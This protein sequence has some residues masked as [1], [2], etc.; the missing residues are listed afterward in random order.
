MSLGEGALGQVRSY[1]VI[2]SLGG[3]CSCSQ[4]LRL[5]GLQFASF[6]C[7]WLFGGSPSVRARGLVDDFAGWFD[8]G[9]L[10]RHEIPWQLE[11]E[12]WINRQNGIVFKH[13]FDWNRPLDVSLPAVREKYARRGARLLRLI[14]AAKRVLAVYLCPPHQREI[15]EE[16]FVKALG[17]L[18]DRFPAVAIDLMVIRCR[19]GVAFADRQDEMRNGVRYVGW[20]YDDGRESFIDNTAMAEFFK[21][22]FVVAD[23]RTEA[24]RHGW[25]A[26]QKALKYAQFN[27]TNAWSYFVNR[28]VYRLY[29]H[30]KR[31]MIR[32]GL[33]RLG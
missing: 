8:P 14:G 10:S 4:S 23:Y 29:R 18:S 33:D 11:H 20:D 16:E 31:S 13:D 12:P 1:D 7:D 17:I 9:A 32:R 22:E 25:P 15:P 19:P 27:A 2:F 24:E 3:A 30:F 5:A 26:R 28:A 6:P 21:A